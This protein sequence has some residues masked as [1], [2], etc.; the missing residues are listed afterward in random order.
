MR[1]KALCV[2]RT[3]NALALPKGRNSGRP[4]LEKLVQVGSGHALGVAASY[5]AA[6]VLLGVVLAV[7]VI[8]VRR[9][10]KIGLGD[11]EDRVLRRRIRAHGN[12]SEYAPLL[13]IILLALPLLGAKEWLIHLVGEIGL[14]GR[15]LHAVGISKSGGTSM[16]RVGGMVLTLAGLLIGAAS[17]LLL[18][19]R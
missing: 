9:A 1:M 3:G 4:V 16:P 7:R 6:L 15:I 8:T 17:L 19:W 18:A 5:I 10:Q 14:L 13:M 12:Y 11:G 2:F